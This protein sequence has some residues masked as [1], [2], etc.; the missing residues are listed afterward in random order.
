VAQLLDVGLDGVGDRPHDRLALGRRDPAPRPLDG[1]TG[2][3][4]GP[5]GVLGAALGQLGDD[6]AGRRVYSRERLPRYC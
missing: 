6:L 3:G 4:D 2:G 1:G 5:V